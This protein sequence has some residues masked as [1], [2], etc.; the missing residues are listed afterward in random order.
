MVL[1]NAAAAFLAA[2]RAADLRDG[3]AMAAGAI[4][5]GS[6]TRLLERLRA[7]KA[8][9]DAAKAAEAAQSLEATRA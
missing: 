1:L 2:G 9:H 7:A 5:G 6:A 8:G 3:I 4:D